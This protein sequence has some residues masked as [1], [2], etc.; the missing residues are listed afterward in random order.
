[1]VNRTFGFTGQAARLRVVSLNFV[2]IL[3]LPPASVAHRVRLLCRGLR[4]SQR[5]TVA[6]AKLISQ[7][8]RG[9]QGTGQGGPEFA[10]RDVEAGDAVIGQVR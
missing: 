10:V 3:V 9:A 2:G 4:S 6:R 5:C 7:R 8:A 1:M